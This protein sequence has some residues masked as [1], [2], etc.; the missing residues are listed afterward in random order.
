M[1]QDCRVLLFITE[2]YTEVIKLLK[3]NSQLA[4]ATKTP[5]NY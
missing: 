2:R 5:P 3:L 1:Q 4:H